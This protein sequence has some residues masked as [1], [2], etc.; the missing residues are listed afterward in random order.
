M[1]ATNYINLYGRELNI[2]RSMGIGGCID[3]TIEGNL[4]YIIGSK[5][6]ENTDFI[7]RKKAAI[8]I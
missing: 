7:G 6:Y 5:K 4:L 1:E 8:H 2:A 3:A